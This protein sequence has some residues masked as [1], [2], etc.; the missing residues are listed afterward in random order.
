[1][2]PGGTQQ[3]PSDGEPYE[4]SSVLVAV[5]MTLF[6]PFIAL[7]AAL[8][9]R[10]S[11]R[12]PARRRQLG[13]WAAAS[14]AYLAVG[15]LLAVALVASFSA[16]SSTDRTGPCVGGPEIGATGEDLGGGRFRFPCAI[17]GSTVVSFPEDSGGASAA[18][19]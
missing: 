10:G 17:S 2:E 18:A 3:T 13:T 5:L 12:D 8:L 14:G 19:A 7:L 16:G 15:V 1:M 6:V 11:E 4:S 9:L